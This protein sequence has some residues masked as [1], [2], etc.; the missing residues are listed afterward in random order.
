LSYLWEYRIKFHKFVLHIWPMSSIW[1][2]FAKGLGFFITFLS[3]NIHSRA[4]RS[5]KSLYVALCLPCRIH[6]LDPIPTSKHRHPSAQG[7]NVSAIFDRSVGLITPSTLVGLSDHHKVAWPQ[8]S[9]LSRLK[10]YQIMIIIIII[11]N[12][13]YIIT[14]YNIYVFMLF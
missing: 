1:K 6:T 10:R 5:S 13:W 3:T 9:G 8:H 2:W 4:T 7:N 14:S 12:P 11:F